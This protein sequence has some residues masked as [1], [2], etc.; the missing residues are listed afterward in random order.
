MRGNKADDMC[1]RFNTNTARDRRTDRHSKKRATSC[2]D[3]R[4]NRYTLMRPRHER[5]ASCGGGGGLAPLPP[6]IEKNV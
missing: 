3:A 6:V 5:W 1:I 4:K 2:A